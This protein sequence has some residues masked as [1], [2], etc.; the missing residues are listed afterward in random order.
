MDTPYRSG[1]ELLM[2]GFLGL[3]LL[4]MTIFVLQVLLG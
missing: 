4:V 1:S 3:G 2:V